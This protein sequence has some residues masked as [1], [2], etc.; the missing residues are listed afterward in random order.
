MSAC[1]ARS[2]STAKEWSGLPPAAQV[3]LRCR[4]SPL[5]AASC[6]AHS[7][8]LAKSVAYFCEGNAIRTGALTSAQTRVSAAAIASVV[9]ITSLVLLFGLQLLQNR[10]LRWQR[11]G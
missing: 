6:R 9:L 4:R 7:M 8:A 3:T 1:V 10:L 2:P 11:G 5:R